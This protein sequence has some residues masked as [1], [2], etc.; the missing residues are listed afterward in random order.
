MKVCGQTRYQTRDLWLKSQ[1]RYRLCYVAELLR[2]AAP[3]RESNRK[4]QRLYPCK[5]RWKNMICAKK[6]EKHEKC[7]KGGKTRWK[8]MR[9]A[10]KVEKHEKCKKG[11]KT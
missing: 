8:N 4:S 6:V 9:S 5:K 10:K 11:G 1:M 3:S 7:K 2:N